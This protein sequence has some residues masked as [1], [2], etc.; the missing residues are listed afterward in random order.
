MRG[1][2]FP[3]STG[4]FT[5]LINNHQPQAVFGNGSVFE[6]ITLPAKMTKLGG[7]QSC[8]GKMSFSGTKLSLKTNTGS[9]VPFF[10]YSISQKKKAIVYECQLKKVQLFK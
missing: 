2:Q 10:L 5:K 9:H 4:R 1:F 8:A 6:E 7:D 3:L